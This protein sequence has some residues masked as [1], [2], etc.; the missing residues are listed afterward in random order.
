MKDC[1]ILVN[2]CDKYEDAW[3]PFF[4][5]L[6]IQW[7]DCPYDMV[8]STETKTYHCDCFDVKTINSDPRLSWS[9]RLKYVLNN[10]ETEYVLFF[11]ED[12]FLLE[13]VRVDI[14]NHALELIKSDPKIGLISFKPRTL[15]LTFPEETDF[16]N[17]IIELDK[18]A[19]RRTNIYVGLWRRENFLSL[20]YGDENPWDYEENANI[21]SRYA[22]FRIYM[23]DHKVSYPAFRYCMDPIDGYGILK[24]KWLC[25]NKELF[26][27]NGIYGV[28]YE[29]LGVFESEMTYEKLKSEIQ[30]SSA[31][32][33]EEQNEPSNTQKRSLPFKESLYKLYKKVKRFFKK[34]KLNYW[35]TCIKYYFYYK[36]R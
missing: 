31:K 25:K 24:G 7:P 33:P 28:D 23:Q 3:D 13:K 29:N 21:R 17:C 19:S 30:K 4:K 12:F 8:L 1:T 16:E 14:F 20:I 32:K 15:D 22:G 34:E 27:A 26:E 36:I 11:L 18:R 9:A 6:K 10:I 2:S 35:K 5:L